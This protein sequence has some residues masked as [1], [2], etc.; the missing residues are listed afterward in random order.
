MAQLRRDFEEFVKRDTVVIAVGPDKKGA[1]KLFWKQNDIPFIGL[2]DHDHKVARLYDQEV[3][4]LKAGRIPA[5]I[6]I[7]KNGVVRFAHYSNSMADIPADEKIF[8]LLDELNK[9]E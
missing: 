9:S 5:Q 7:D 4:L 6:V 2:S 8:E 1:F 3:N